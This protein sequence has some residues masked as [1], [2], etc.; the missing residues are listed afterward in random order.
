[1]S[2][3]LVLIY[4]ND[5]PCIPELFKPGFVYERCCLTLS[6][7]ESDPLSKP[8]LMMPS[9][10][11]LDSS[12]I[13]HH[14]T[15]LSHP[16]DRYGFSPTSFQATLSSIPILTCYFEAIKH[17]Y[18]WEAMVDKV[19]A[20]KIIIHEMLF[21]AQQLLKLMFISGFTRSNFVLM[22]LWIDIKHNLLLLVP[23]KNIGWTMRRVLLWLLR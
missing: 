8:I 3:I 20:L 21:L 9:M 23:N 16:L 1:V 10:I 5:L 22:G 4:F 18:W 19:H 13:P 17:E 2:K 14:S 11:E 12:P 15:R 6:L 7:L